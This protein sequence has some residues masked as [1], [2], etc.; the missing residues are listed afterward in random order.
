MSTKKNEKRFYK[1]QI[2]NSAKFGK[3]RDLLSAVLEEEKAYTESEI[4]K[5]INNYMERRV[6]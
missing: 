3:Y 5:A 2:I 6:D 4:N 1:E